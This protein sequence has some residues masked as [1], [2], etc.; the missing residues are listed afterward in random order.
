MSAPT[1]INKEYDIIIAGGTPS[2]PFSL[3]TFLFFSFL[4]AVQL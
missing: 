1:A 3:F 4:T 2:S